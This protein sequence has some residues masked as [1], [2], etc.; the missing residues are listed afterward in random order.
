VQFLVEMFSALPQDLGRLMTD[1]ID[2]GEQRFRATN[3][4]SY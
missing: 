3:M 4:A 2:G 1:N